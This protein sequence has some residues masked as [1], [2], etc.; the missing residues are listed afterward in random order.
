MN[1]GNIKIKNSKNP[2]LRK[3]GIGVLIGLAF[4]IFV[5]AENVPYKEG[6]VYVCPL[7]TNMEEI[8][9][10]CN[11][12][13]DLILGQTITK[14]CDL[15]GKTYEMTLIITEHEGKEYYTILGFENGGA[16]VIEDARL[17]TQI[18]ITEMI[19]GNEDILEKVTKNIGDGK[20]PLLL[21]ELK[22]TNVDLEDYT[23][24]G[25]INP[26]VKKKLKVK[27]KFLETAGNEYQGKSINAKFIFKATQEEQ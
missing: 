23:F 21:S 7:A 3:S 13:I 9:P 15:N 1:F 24:D 6:R 16:G 11:C 26:G 18:A 22:G 17:E 20:A 8:N 5:F 12:R 27:F 25:K 10:E 4:T 19:Y 14:T 2:L